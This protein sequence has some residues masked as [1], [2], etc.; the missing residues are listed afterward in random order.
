MKEVLMSKRKKAQDQKI[1]EPRRIVERNIVNA[2][3]LQYDF[4]FW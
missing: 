4:P 2:D 1:A 3:A